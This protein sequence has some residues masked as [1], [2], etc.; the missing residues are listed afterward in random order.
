MSF[1]SFAG[2]S[3]L[4]ISGQGVVVLLGQFGS[5]EGFTKIPSTHW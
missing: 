5:A 2:Y 1:M 3:I 4:Q